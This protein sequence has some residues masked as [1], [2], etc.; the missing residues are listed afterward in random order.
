VKRI[1]YTKTHYERRVFNE[2][3]VVKDSLGNQ[4]SYNSWKPKYESGDFTLTKKDISDSIYTLRWLSAEAKKQR[5]E[6]APAPRQTPYFKNGEKIRSFITRDIYGNKIDLESFHDK[7]VV[8]NFFTTADCGSCKREMVALNELVN[9]LGK[10]QE[11]VVLSV[12]CTNKPETKEFLKNLGTQLS[13]VISDEDRKITGMYG[14]KTY[15]VNVV[16]DGNGI[17]R[18]H[19]YGTSPKNID[20]IQKT[21]EAIIKEK[22]VSF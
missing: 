20:Y 14:I 18:F 12:T 13:T 15:P 6:N 19:S 1:K 4:L 21:I 8:I 3:T 11:V 16:I 10:K 7:V 5:Y 2:S 17:V 22:G 9:E